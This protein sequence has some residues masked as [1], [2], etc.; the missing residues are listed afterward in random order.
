MILMVVGYAV[1]IAVNAGANLGWFGKT[2]AEVSKEWPIPITPSGWAFAIW[3]V[4][5]GLQG[6]GTIYQLC[7]RNYGSDGEKESAV[8]AAGWIQGAWLCQCFWQVSFSKEKFSLCIGL[9]GGALIF[10]YYTTIQL[11]AAKAS[12]GMGWLSEICYSIPTS[13]NAAWLTA[14][15]SLQLGIALKSYG[16]Q[17]GTLEGTCVVLVALAGLVAAW[18]VV[19]CK[20]YAWGLTTIWALTAIASNSPPTAVFVSC[21]ICGLVL[22]LALLHTIT[23]AVLQAAV[24]KSENKAE[25]VETNPQAQFASA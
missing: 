23:R 24:A 12:T 1:L 22:L 14:A 20:N 17:A 11:M 6:F 4:I 21:A 16:V 7:P 25:A 19:A 2:N 3:G 8:L 15:T 9:I 5:F 13:I 10:G 18:F